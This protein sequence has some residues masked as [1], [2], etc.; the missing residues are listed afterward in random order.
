M[1]SLVVDS[2]VDSEVTPLQEPK[3]LTLLTTC[4]FHHGDVY[5]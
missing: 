2:V 3:R 4:D 5:T 1:R